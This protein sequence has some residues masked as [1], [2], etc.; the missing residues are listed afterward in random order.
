MMWYDMINYE[1]IL[2]VF[3]HKVLFN[4]LKN[5]LTI[6][7]YTV[8]FNRCY[9]LTICAYMFLNSHKQSVLNGALVAS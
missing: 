4:S 1:M 9:M 8:A 3:Y 6:L 2:Y 7:Y 5:K